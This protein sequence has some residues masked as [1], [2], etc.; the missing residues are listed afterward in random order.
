M[1]F[2]DVNTTFDAQDDLLF[3]FQ[4]T[5]VLDTAEMIMLV[6]MGILV[7]LLV[8]RPL[9]SSMV[10]SQKAAIDQAK[11]EAALLAAQAAPAALTGPNSGNEV[12]NEAFLNDESDDIG[13]GS[14]TSHDNEQMV[15]M[16]SV[17]GKVKA[18]SVKKVGE[19]VSG[20]PNETVSVIRNW[21]TQE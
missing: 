12:N 18:S 11:E 14:D 2:A 17:E 7:I 4:H 1:Q 16:Q 19:I 13:A 8:I 9:V 6:I 20:H 15:D 10:M 3:G 5:Q 21:M